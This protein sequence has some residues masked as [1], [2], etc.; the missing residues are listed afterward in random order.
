MADLVVRDGYI[1]TLDGE[2]PRMEKGSVLVQ[3]GRVSSI[4]TDESHPSE[5]DSAVRSVD[6]RGRLIMP[7]LVNAHTHLAGCV[8]RGLLDDWTYPSSGLHA[9]A[10]PMELELTRD[11]Y[12]WLSLLGAIETV[13]AGSTT[14]SDMYHHSETAAQAAH[15]VGL[16]AVIAHKVYDCDL[17][18]VGRGDYSRSS[19]IRRERVGASVRLF[20]NWHGRAGGRIT[21]RVGA[22]ATDTCSEDLLQQMRRMADE[23]GAGLHIHVAQSPA[24]VAH[25]RKM[26]G[27]SPVAYLQQLDFLRPDVEVVHLT[28]ASGE[29][30]DILQREG[31]T[32]AHCAPR[33]GRSGKYPPLKEAHLDRAIPTGFGTDWLRMDMWDGMRQTASNM[34]LSSGEGGLLSARDL[35]HLCTQG[36]ARVLGMEDELGVLRPGAAADMILIDLDRPK[37]QPFFGTAQNVVFHVDGGDVD[38]VI[39]AGEEIVR[40]GR[41][42]HVDEAEV[43]RQ[44]QKRI[45]RFLQILERLYPAHR[46]LTGKNLLAD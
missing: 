27:L 31:A 36:A 20:E 1:M 7:G 21:C 34:S 15:E 24:E 28:E 32:Y 30:L 22:H 18:A 29:D 17:R 46:A 2:R 38:G 42:L 25:I 26:H 43:L 16:R 41:C 40:E 35:L 39:V 4:V 14:I 6:A 37:L 12:Y 23:Y 8:F 19:R 9:L 33:Y 13:R 5:L 11:D 45:P 3:D 10:F 44:V